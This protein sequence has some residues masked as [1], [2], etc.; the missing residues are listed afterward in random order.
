MKGKIT[1][2][3]DEEEGMVWL[4]L[5]LSQFV[6]GPRWCKL[7]VLIKEKIC[8]NYICVCVCEFKLVFN[9]SWLIKS[10]LYW[11]VI[12]YRHDRY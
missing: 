2:W 1:T 6:H 7:W 11:L 3:D 4:L 8:F 12:I 5:L 10:W 9:L